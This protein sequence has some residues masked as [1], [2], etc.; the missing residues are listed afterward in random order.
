MFR[1][2]ARRVVGIPC[3]ATDHECYQDGYVSLYDYDES[4]VC[5]Y[6]V[7]KC[8]FC[9]TIFREKVDLHG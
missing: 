1:R 7:L 9:G 6:R 3:A 2:L 4:R 5:Y 8:R